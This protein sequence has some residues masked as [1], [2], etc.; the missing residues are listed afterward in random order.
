MPP[1]GVEQI[2]GGPFLSSFGEDTP[3]FGSF[4]MWYPQN[5]Q[6]GMCRQRTCR[7][8]LTCMWLMMR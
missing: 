1:T 6:Q 3:R 4:P 8:D 7:V 2:A 5:V